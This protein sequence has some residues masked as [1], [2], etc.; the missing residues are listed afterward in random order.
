[1]LFRRGMAVVVAV[2]GLTVLWASPASAHALLLRTEPAPQSTVA[3]SPRVLSLFFSEAVEVSAGD[4]RLYDVDG[5]RVDVG[6]PRRTNGNSEVSVSLPHLDDG[7]YTVVW[8]AVS[9]DSHPVRG[10]FLFYVGHPSSISAVAIGG[11]QGPRQAVTTAFWAVRLL[12]FAAITLI[13]GLFAFRRF[14]WTPAVRESGEAASQAAAAFRTRFNRLIRI[15]WLVLAVAAAG[16]LVFQTATTQDTSVVSAL[17]WSRLST[18]LGESFGRI[19]LVE[20][21]CILVLALPVFALARPTRVAG[22]PPEAWLALAGVAI[23]GLC[24]LEA[25]AGHARTDSRPALVVAAAAIHL[26]AVAAWVGG[27]AVL[28]TVGRSSWRRLE[29]AARTDLVGAIVRRF[30]QFAIALVGM[31]TLT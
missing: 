3:Q 4:V 25:L 1:M 13:V 6:A 22:I 27:L 16:W 10:G 11:N 29:H 28:L 19:W 9:G 7:T 20:G 18:L 14:V 5:K 17:S 8:R 31:V 15:A 26:L 21:L 24:L 23:W 30:S 12:W 2:A